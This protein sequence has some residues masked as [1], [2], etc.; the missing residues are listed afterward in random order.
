M[1][2]FLILAVLMLFLAP[3]IIPACASTVSPSSEAAKIDNLRLVGTIGPLSV[4]LAYMVENN[5][6]ASIARQTTLTV[7]ANPTQLQAVMAGGQGD[8][9]S[10]PTTSA[11]TF[12]NRGISLELL[13]CSIWNILYV[14]TADSTIRSV[15]DL[16]G[17]RVVVPYQGA[18]PDA[19][20]KYIC[21]KQGL[22]PDNVQ[23]IDIFYAADPV[24]ASQLLLTG[25]EKY[26]LL[27]EP[28]ATAVILK[29]KSSGTPLY[30][31]LNM[32]TEWE[33]AAGGKSTPIAG[34][35]A[36]G[37][38]KNRPEVV[39]TFLSEYQKA[40]LWMLANPAE[41]GQVGAKVLAE[42]GFTA[43]ALTESLKSINWQFVSASEA[44]PAIQDFFNALAELSPNYFGGKLPD[45][46]FYHG[47]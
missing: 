6:L 39:N 23:D 47:R 25:Q 13:D 3:S 1:K 4:P 38:L 35:V 8:F 17:K 26:V 12:Y 5:R 24:Q 40:V 36:L 9:V 20:F 16:K 33:K 34:T 2:R 22:N 7:W 42:Q 31:V 27:S 21:L 18:I 32:K 28:S 46:A 15:Q 10:L 43:A 37:E 19:M 30:R 11:A 14:V 44:R 45:N 41:A 29:S